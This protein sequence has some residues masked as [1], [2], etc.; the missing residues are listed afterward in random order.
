MS[1]SKTKEAQL[2]QEVEA[3]RAELA[4]HQD[5][6]REHVQTEDALRASEQRYKSLYHDTPVMMHS[7]DDDARLV[8]VNDHWLL[9]TGYERDEVLGRRVTDFMPEELR[10]KVL[11]EYIPGLRREQSVRNIEVQFVKKNGEVLDISVSAIAEL[12]TGK[13]DHSLAVLVDITDHKRAEKALME[14][15]QRFRLLVEH[16][17]DAFYL[18]DP[19][20]RLVDVNENACKALGY[21]RDELLTMSVPDFSIAAD[22]LKKILE[23]VVPGQPVTREVVHRRKDGTSFPVEVRIGAFEM[24]NAKFRVA[25][26]RDI[27]KRK[28]AERALVESEQRFRLLMEHAADAF[29]LIDTEGRLVDV[30]ESACTSLGYTREELLTM[31]VP[32]LGVPREEVEK[33]LKEFTPDEPLTREG[34]QRRK[35]GTSFPV[36]VRIGAF[37]VGKDKYRLAL[38]RDITERKQAEAALRDSKQRFAGILHSAMDAIVTIDH[39]RRITLFNEA[40]QRI[41]GC[42]ADEACGQPV[43]RFL[44]EEFQRALDECLGAEQEQG[45][46]RYLWVPDGIAALRADGEE[47]PVEATISRAQIGGKELCTI[48]LRD[49]NERMRAEEEIRRLELERGYLREEVATQL[50][51]Y[52]FVGSSTSMQRVLRDIETVA[53]TDST[54]LISGET[55][56]GKELV[57]RAIHKASRRK[58]AAMVKVNCAVLSEGLIES[59]MFG[60]EKGA[61]TGAVSRKIGRFELADGGTIFLDEIG[62]LPP[63]LQT[64]LLR[65]LQEGE[66][67]RVGGSATITCDVR[68]IVATNR[69]L[70][71]AVDERRF[72][73]DL[74]YRINVF[75]IRVP[76]LR[77]RLDDVPLLAKYFLAKYATKAGKRIS[78]IPKRG[79]KALTSY[80]WPGNVRE[81]QNVIERAVILSRGRELELGDWLTR[82]SPVAAGSGISSL[83]D[84]QRQ[85]ILRV[86]ELTGW[87]VSGQRG[88][89]ELLGLKPT[90]LESRMFKLGIQRKASGTP[91]IS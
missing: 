1:A 90:T 70:T 43:E 28:R 83:D 77:E 25:L 86:L 6:E 49:I 56:T 16:A 76:P 89:A 24:G 82:P 26:A 35:D 61:F 84:I 71:K 8:A 22:S 44:S 59:E 85:H 65:V 80:H 15:E 79:L 66:F 36:E 38:A 46:Q 55:G 63:E 54:V 45:D 20:G 40:A 10:R 87:R 60:H 51:L 78:T 31:S 2:R 12:E 9:T 41:F 14:S 39:D 81:L 75:P 62:E 17:A 34:I 91:T 72:R 33:V 48:I 74:F 7:I 88:A 21:T 27:T 13:I 73:S 19:K 64:K 57:A 29:F 52:E 5:T 11:D 47:F 32:D 3:L 23:Q 68:V 53:P 50:N 4:L 67:D 30:N 18:V 58:D 37:E 42:S 69:D